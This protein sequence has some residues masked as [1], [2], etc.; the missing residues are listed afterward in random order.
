VLI[1]HLPHFLLFLAAILTSA[2]S[3]PAVKS[4]GELRERAK[5]SEGYT[6]ETID[7]GKSFGDVAG[8]MKRLS[9]KCLNVA[10]T[11]DDFRREYYS[12]LTVDRDRAVMTLQRQDTEGMLFVSSTP[13]KAGYTMVVDARAQPGSA[14]RLTLHWPSRGFDPLYKA[15]RERLLGQGRGCPSPEIFP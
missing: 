6:F 11:S 7:I 10:L 9:G 13:R 15:V 8:N 1:R 2:C 4:A 5:A 14:T 12:N 3:I